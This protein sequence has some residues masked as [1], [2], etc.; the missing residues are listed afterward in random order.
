VE[1]R[2]IEIRTAELEMLAGGIAHIRLNDFNARA[3]AQLRQALEDAE[4]QGASAVILD[5]RD[6]PGG[7]LDQAVAVADEFL[8]AGPVVTERGRLEAA[9]I[10]NSRDG[11]LATELPLAVLI[12][13]GSASASEIVAGAVQ[14]RDRGVLVGERSYGKGSVQ[15]AFDLSDGSELRVTVARWYTPDDRLIQGEGL[16]PDIVVPA[17]DGDGDPQL[18]A[19]VLHLM[20][21]IR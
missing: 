7:F 4:R 12:N 14:A 21:I 17:A 15:L 6:N 10:H 20:E 13:G 19:A 2:E 18:D 9:R 11:G 1:R 5:L 8:N 16:Q 3:V